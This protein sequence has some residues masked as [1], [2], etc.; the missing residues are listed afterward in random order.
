MITET[1]S[2]LPAPLLVHLGKVF[3]AI[4][5]GTAGYNFPDRLPGVHADTVVDSH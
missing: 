2:L 3:L 1:T 4:P 5:A